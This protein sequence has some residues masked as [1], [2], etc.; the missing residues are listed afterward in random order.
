MGTQTMDAFLKNAKVNIF[1]YSPAAMELALEAEEKGTY[2]CGEKCTCC[3]D[4]EACSKIICIAWYRWFQ[5]H[6]HDIQKAGEAM[7]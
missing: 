2:P 6:W 1:S 4:P 3:K 5:K 7:K